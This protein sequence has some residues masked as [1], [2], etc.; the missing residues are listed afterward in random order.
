MP[1]VGPVAIYGMNLFI[2]LMNALYGLDI[3]F[4]CQQHSAT[5][6]LVSQYFLIHTVAVPIK[7]CSDMHR[8]IYVHAE[9]VHIKQDEQLY[10]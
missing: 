9:Y 1:A 4:K 3:S 8:Y 2:Q 7:L 5:W 6:S 10:W